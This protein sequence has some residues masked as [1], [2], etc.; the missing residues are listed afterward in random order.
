MVYS[1]CFQEIRGTN[2]NKGLLGR[3]H[4]G[5]HGRTEAILNM[6]VC[7]ACNHFL[8]FHKTGGANEPCYL[9]PPKGCL[10]EGC[11]CAEYKGVMLSDRP[12]EEHRSMN[13]V[14]GT[15][16]SVIFS[17]DEDRTFVSGGEPQVERA[18]VRLRP[19]A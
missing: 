16:G 7:L 2:G 6:H 8:V 13:M 1:R 12:H 18:G 5:S 15:W 17:T 9:C 10:V 3:S 11:Q 19:G 4:G 14:W